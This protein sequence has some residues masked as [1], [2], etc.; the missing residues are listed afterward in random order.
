MMSTG[1]AG[2]A[3]RFFQ[4][5]RQ[6]KAP[7]PEATGAK[8]ARLLTQTKQGADKNPDRRDR[9]QRTKRFFT[10]EGGGAAG[11]VAGRLSGT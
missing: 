6:R 9:S 1:G 11:H 4:V 3:V 2:R 7:A 5:V 8:N 10:Y